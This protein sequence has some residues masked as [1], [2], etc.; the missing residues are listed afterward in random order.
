VPLAA[1]YRLTEIEETRIR[2]DNSLSP[3][4]KAVRLEAMRIAQQD[5]MRQILG[6][7]AY[8]RYLQTLR[9]PTQ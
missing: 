6:D 3:D 7:E 1:I 4:E 2:S 5:S 9:L 8:L